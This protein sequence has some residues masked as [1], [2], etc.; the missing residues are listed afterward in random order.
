MSARD[1]GYLLWIAANPGGLPG[2]RYGMCASR[3]QRDIDQL[4][5]APACPAGEVP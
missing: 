4:A 3:R 5:L 1:E 2:R